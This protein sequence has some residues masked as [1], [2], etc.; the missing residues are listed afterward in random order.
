MQEIKLT[1]QN[2]LGLHARCAA[3][4][5]KTASKAKGP[6]FLSANG[7]TADATDILDMLMLAPHAAQGMEISI[8]IQETVDQDILDE[9]AA[10]VQDGF[11]ED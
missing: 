6:V 1:I 8:A 10:L 2:E 11:G 4:V 7:N 3:L 5:A 9:L